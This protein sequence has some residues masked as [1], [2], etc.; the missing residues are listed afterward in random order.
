MQSQTH[1]WVIVNGSSINMHWIALK[2]LQTNL[3]K[4]LLKYKSECFVYTETWNCHCFS[5]KFSMKPDCK[6]ENYIRQ[7]LYK[8]HTT[9]TNFK[10]IQYTL[11]LNTPDIF[12]SIQTSVL[13]ELANW[14]F[15]VFDLRY[16][17][18]SENNCRLY[19]MSCY[20]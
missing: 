20:V 8:W 15:S 10:T 3:Q 2:L 13:L 9:T 16:L 1:L 7:T 19:A 11:T 4:Y 14:W 18:N 12:Y 5:L 17:I 6:R